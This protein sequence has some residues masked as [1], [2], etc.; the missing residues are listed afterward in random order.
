MGNTIPEKNYDIEDSV[1]V[2]SLFIK[3]DTN[4]STIQRYLYHESSSKSFHI[5]VKT[6]SMNEKALKTY[7]NIIKVIQLHSPLHVVQILHKKQIDRNTMKLYLKDHGCFDLFELKCHAM[8]RFN[9][10]PSHKCEIYLY[11]IARG[12]ESLHNL[13]IVHGDIKPE[14]VVIDSGKTDKAV[15]IDLDG[16]SFHSMR[17]FDEV[18][19]CAG[20]KGYVAPERM[21]NNILCKA[22]DVWSFGIL[23][24][25]LFEGYLPLGTDYMKTIFKTG[26]PMLKFDYTPMW[27][28]QTIRKSIRLNHKKRL[29]MKEI[30]DVLVIAI[31]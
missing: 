16:A 4:R 28:R 1:F 26:V 20:T 13:G 29:S 19:V 6:I 18:H 10:I 3:N 14:N 8:R 23:M 27:L 9:K 17:S 22:N 21:K 2:E 25:E 30:V 5:I 15:I 24:F 31:L 11:Q 12:I 7:K